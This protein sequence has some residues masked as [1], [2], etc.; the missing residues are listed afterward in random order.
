[1]RVSARTRG[2]DPEDPRGSLESVDTV[3][4]PGGGLRLATAGDEWS[5]PLPPAR[6]TVRPACGMDPALGEEAPKE[7]DLDPPLVQR[8]KRHPSPG[9]GGQYLVWVGRSPEEGVISTNNL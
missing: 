3:H 9:R 6:V 1:M 4:N 8:T 2:K 7:R 5:G